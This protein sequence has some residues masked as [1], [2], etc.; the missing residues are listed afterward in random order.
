MVGERGSDD[1][2]D[3]RNG[4]V[5]LVNTLDGR[6]EGLAMAIVIVV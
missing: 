2:L 5:I 4:V 6:Q 3:V 1:W